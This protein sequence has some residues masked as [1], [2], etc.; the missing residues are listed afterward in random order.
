MNPKNRTVS[1]V[2]GIGLLCLLPASALATGQQPDVIIYNGKTYALFAN[3]LEEFYKDPKR[4]QCN[5]S[6]SKYVNMEDK[7]VKKVAAEYPA[8]PGFRVEGKVTVRIVVNKKGNVISA[9]AICGHPLLI[10]PSIKA[11]LRWQFQPQ[12]VDGRPTKNIGVIVFILED[13]NQNER[14]S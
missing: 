1:A 4:R 8:E 11:A 13:T 5:E 6:I 9:R 14:H 12:L 2:I 7:A 3:P 10:A